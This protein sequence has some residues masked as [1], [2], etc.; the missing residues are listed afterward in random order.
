MRSMALL[1]AGLLLAGPAEAATTIYYRAGSWH[2]F[3]GVNGRG[4]LVCGMG[5][6]NPVDGRRLEISYLIGGTRLLFQTSKPTWNIPPGA[7]VP[8]VLEVGDSV[9]WTAQ[10][11]GRGSGRTGRFPRTRSPRSTPRSARPGP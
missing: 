3:S 6:G 5:T 1:G 7:A 10:A 11:S 9:P 4:E 8:V 2:A